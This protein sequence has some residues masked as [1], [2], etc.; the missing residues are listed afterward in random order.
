MKYL[1][2]LFF[3]ITFTTY[4]KAQKVI[5]KAYMDN[6]M[7][8]KNS[9]TIY[10]D[11]NRVLDWSDFQG[12]PNMNHFGGAVTASGF[13]FDSEM[14]YD[15]NTLLINI[16]VDTYFSKKSSW[17]KSNISS[18][19][20]L[21]HEQHHFDITRIGAVKLVE[22][23]G[24]AKFTEANYKTLLNAIFENAYK[25]NNLLQQ[26]YDGETVHSLDTMKQAEWNDRINTA[27]KKLQA[28]VAVGP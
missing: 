12:Q 11:F 16:S 7:A 8:G 27:M 2:L 5:V 25:E 18:A 26:Q 17:K 22:E 23:L 28:Q 3:F 14:K 24:K 1:S 13:A 9:D 6:K 15:G 4:L 19:Y 21:K 20:H 10:Y